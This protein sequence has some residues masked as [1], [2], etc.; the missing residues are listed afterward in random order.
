MERR[1][2][3]RIDSHQLEVQ[4]D[5]LRDALEPLLATALSHNA[6]K[7]PLLDKAKLYVLVT[8]AIESLLFCLTQPAAILRLD[9]INSREHPVFRELAR[10]KQYFE[11]IKDAEL[12]G[13]KRDNLCL[14]KEAANRFIKHALAGNEKHDL[15]RAEQQAKERAK[16]HIKFE[17]LS[18]KRKAVDGER[19]SSESSGSGE[20]PV[21]TQDKSQIVDTD[22]TK[23]KRKRRG[24]STQGPR[25]VEE[26]EEV[27]NGNM[28][29]DRNRDPPPTSTEGN[30]PLSEHSVD[31]RAPRKEHLSHKGGT[32]SEEM[33]ERTQKNKAKTNSRRKA[34]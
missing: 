31:V 14:D 34:R 26:G 23:G 2:K 7:L 19:T 8:Y 32:A 20:R 17:Q 10:V 29:L 16:A 30:R 15:K 1:S 12:S 4:I 27:G 25:R 5:D 11:K 3:S 13:T 22:Q 9:G 28:I 21:T 18:R 24:P 33:Q 6:A